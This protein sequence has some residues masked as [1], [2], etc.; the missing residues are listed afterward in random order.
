MRYTPPNP[1]PPVDKIEELRQEW[2]KVDPLDSRLDRT[3]K[4]LA[5]AAR[6]DL[7]RFRQVCRELADET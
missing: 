2:L 5:I 1:K 6:L 3:G 7:D 4:V